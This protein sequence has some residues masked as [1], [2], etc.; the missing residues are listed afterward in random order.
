MSMSEPYETD[1]FDRPTGLIEVP[2]S[3]IADDAPY[4]SLPGGALSS[5]ELV[6]SIYR[7]DFDAAYREGTLFVLTRDPMIAGRPAYLSQLEKPISYMKAKPGVWFA[8]GRQI[9]EI[10]APKGS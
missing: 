8:T 3:W 10:M 1:S 2:P 4:L 7:E 9:A 5:P 6:F